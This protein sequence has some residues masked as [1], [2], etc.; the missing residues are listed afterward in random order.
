M[1]GLLLNL[2]ALRKTGREWFGDQGVLPHTPTR[3][4]PGENLMSGSRV[5]AGLTP[6]TLMT[7]LGKRQ[8]TLHKTYTRNSM[9]LLGILGP[10]S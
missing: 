5:L 8:S 7:T 2:R 1:V 4:R 9:E 6:V 3:A 10:V